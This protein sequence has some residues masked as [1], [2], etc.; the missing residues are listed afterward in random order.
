MWEVLRGNWEEINEWDY[1]EIIQKKTIRDIEGEIIELLEGNSIYI[2]KIDGNKLEVR[3]QTG[4]IEEQVF[5]N[6]ES[7]KKFILSKRTYLNLKSPHSYH[8]S[9]P[10]LI[11]AKVTR[12]ISK[13]LGKK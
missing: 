3:I 5:G 1:L 12:A 9:K 7:I 11:I 10:R 13:N 6:G 4:G 2:E 8:I